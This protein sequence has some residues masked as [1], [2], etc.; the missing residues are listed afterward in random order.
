LRFLFGVG[1]A[2]ANFDQESVEL[3]F[4]QRIGALEF[5]WI[6]RGEDREGRG[7]RVARAVDGDLFLFHSF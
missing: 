7:E 3:G 6:L 1:I 5:D 4:G 2:D